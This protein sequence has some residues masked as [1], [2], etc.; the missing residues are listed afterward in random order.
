MTSLAAVA[1]SHNVP[2]P[3][4]TGIRD[5]YPLYVVVS[6]VCDSFTDSDMSV[7]LVS[8][9]GDGWKRRI[10]PTSQLNT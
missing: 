2:L 8:G 9:M 5:G 7:T 6:E 3:W 10:S 1:N 4:D